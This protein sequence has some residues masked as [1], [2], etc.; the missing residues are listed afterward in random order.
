MLSRAQKDATIAQLRQD[1]EGAGA[2]ILTNLIGIASNDAVEVR[3]KI[4]ENKGKI[5]ITRNTLFQKAAEGTYAEALLKDLKGPHALAITG[6]NAPA[7]AKTLKQTGEDFEAVDFK[8]GFLNG[9][10][11]SIAQIGELADL[12]SREEMLGTLLASMMAPLSSL[13]RLLNAIK[14]EC[15]DRKVDSPKNL[16]E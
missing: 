12:P 3:K 7:V 5:V 2:L 9:R 1:I 14:D 16:T 11:L 4:R 13:A 15:Q 8:G 6:E 10:E